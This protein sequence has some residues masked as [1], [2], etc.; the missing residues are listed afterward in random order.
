MEDGQLVA[1]VLEEPVLGLGVEL[2]AVRARGGVARGEVALGDA[3]AQRD[4]AAGLVRLLRARMLLELGTGELA[5]WRITG[6]E[7]SPLDLQA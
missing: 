1:V 6:G 7:V 4:Q 3:V 2:E 5:A